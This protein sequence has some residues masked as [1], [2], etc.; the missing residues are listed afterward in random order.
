MVVTPGDFGSQ[1]A[2]PSHP[3]LLDWLAV[4]FSTSD[5][6]IKALLKAI[7]RSATYR[8]SVRS[9]PKIRQLDPDNILLARGPGG[10]L[11]A[12]MIRDHALAI[13]GPFEARKSEGQA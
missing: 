13:S 12:E 7:V 2:L 11:P 5:W 4:E 9:N 1:G 6:D 8:Q 10:R 3:E